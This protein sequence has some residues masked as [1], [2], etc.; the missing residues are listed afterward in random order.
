M[1]DPFIVIEAA[2]GMVAQRVKLGTTL[3]D[4]EELWHAAWLDY[5]PL[6]SER[7]RVG[8]GHGYLTSYQQCDSDAVSKLTTKWLGYRDAVLPPPEPEDEDD[9]VEAPPPE[10]EPEVVDPDTFMSEFMQ[11]RA[12]EISRRYLEADHK[13]TDFKG[14]YEEYQAGV[15]A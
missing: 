6:Q 8:L 11:D 3:E 1:S 9:A 13:I 12:N 14:A 4:L 15:P 2:Y 7:I 10:S 5:N